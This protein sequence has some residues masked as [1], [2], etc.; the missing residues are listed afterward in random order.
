MSE[1]RHYWVATVLPDGSPH[2]RPVDGVWLD[3]TLY[4]GGSD[5]TRWRRN[6]AGDPGAC[7]NLE[8]GQQAVILHGAV[9]VEK[10]GAQLATRLAEG[11][12]TKY[13]YGQT[14]ATYEGKEVLA[15]RPDTA[16]AWTLLY[17]DATRF[18]RVAER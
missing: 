2:T 11:S 13:G 14:A 18:E 6:L 17:R 7:V 1:A 3:D 8:P 4:F 15:F 10:P 9:S 16:F 12:N 5:E